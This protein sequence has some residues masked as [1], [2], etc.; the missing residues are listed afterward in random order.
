MTTQAMGLAWLITTTM[1]Q[2][3]ADAGTETEYREP[4]IG[5]AAADAPRFLELRR[6]AAPTHLLPRDLLPG[7]RSVVSFFLPFAPW[8]VGAN[9]E[10]REQVAREWAVAYVETNAL[11]RRITAHLIEVLADQGIRAAAEPATHNF[12]PVTLV[13]RW[14]HK[15]VAVI[16][17]LGSLGLHHMVIT[18]AGCAGRFGSLVLNA[19]LPVTPTE[20]RE[21]CLYFY[22]GSCLECVMRCPVAALEANGPESGSLDKQRCH[23]HLHTVAEAYGSLGLADVCGKCAVG[24]CSFESA[25]ESTGP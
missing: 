3:V 21:R 4:R 12:D 16:A 19:D 25:V 11:I 23:S 15:S 24:P 20:P 2:L 1:R 5:F 6:V 8:V 9:A 17:G 7:A 22:D 13:S 18:D 10:Q 14:S